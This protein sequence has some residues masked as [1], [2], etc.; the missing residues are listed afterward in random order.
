M[1]LMMV[2]QNLSREEVENPETEVSFPDSVVDMMRGNLGQPPG[3]FP[4]GIVAKV[5]KGEAPNLT[6]PGAHLAPVDLDQTRA[7]LSKLLEGKAV[8]D[9]DLNGYLMYPKVFLDYMGR[10][11]QYGPVR[12]LPT[13]AF[14]YGMEP[15]EEITAEIDPGKTLEIRMQALGETDEKGEVK[16]FFELN[17]QPRVIRVPNRLVKATTESRPKAEAGNANHIGAPMPGVVASVA[18]Q[19]GQEV[20]EGDMLL[21]IEAMKMETGL[22]AERSARVK[23]LHVAA[24]TQI[25]AKDLLIELEDL[26]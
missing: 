3:G 6:R 22:H 4:D 11:R 20:H 8:D 21:T 16:V 10:H 18:V 13:R 14:F 1:A 19:L 17:G 7:E 12:T 9:E 25:D 26:D 2:S 15:G 23:A 24:G 5:L